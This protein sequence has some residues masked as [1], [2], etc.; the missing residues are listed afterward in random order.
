MITTIYDYVMISYLVWDLCLR[1]QSSLDEL[2]ITFWLSDRIDRVGMGGVFKVGGG[3]SLPNPVAQAPPPA[4]KEEGGGEY[5]RG[6]D[7]L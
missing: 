5:L 4:Q 7:L 3:G 1:D 6:G 2:S